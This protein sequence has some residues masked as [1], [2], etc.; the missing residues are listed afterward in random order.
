MNVYSKKE[1]QVIME[2]IAAN[3]N[4]QSHDLNVSQNK[5]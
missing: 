4:K 1:M 2:R 3:W 5:Q